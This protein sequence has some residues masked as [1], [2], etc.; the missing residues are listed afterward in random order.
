MF[1]MC[2]AQMQYNI[3]WQLRFGNLKRRLVGAKFTRRL[4]GGGL[5]SLWM[6]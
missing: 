6:I 2:Q 1:V 5:V 4:C 3:M